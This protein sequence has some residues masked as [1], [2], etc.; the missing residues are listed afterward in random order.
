MARYRS[1]RA[2]LS[3]E[4]EAELIRQ[5]GT[6]PVV[7]TLKHLK[8]PL[9]RENYLDLAYMGNPPEVLSAEEEAELPPEI[10]KWPTSFELCSIDEDGT[11]TDAHLHEEILSGIDPADEE[12][13]LDETR[14]RAAERGFTPEQIKKLYG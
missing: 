14:K 9:T 7:E 13:L 4:Q 8:I 5:A 12:R 3:S 2:P 11:V 6:D 1:T 10:Q